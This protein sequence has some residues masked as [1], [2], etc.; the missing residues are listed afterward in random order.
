VLGPGRLNFVLD[1]VPFGLHY[2]PDS[3]RVRLTRKH[4]GPWGPWWLADRFQGKVPVFAHTKVIGAKPKGGRLELRLVDTRTGSQSERVVDHVIAGTG[5]E[6]D[7]YSLPFMDRGLCARIE[8]IER[9][10]RVFSNFET[11]IAGLH[12]MGPATAMSFGPLMRFVAGAKYASETIAAHLER[13]LLRWTPL[14]TLRT[15]LR[16]NARGWR[17]AA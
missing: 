3:F 9:G 1:R 11:S 2:M 15:V 7:L 12:F 13:D 17:S 4:L 6:P 16:K 14:H 5:Y 10:P 8:L